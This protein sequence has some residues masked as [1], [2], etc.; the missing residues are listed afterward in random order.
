MITSKKCS[1]LKNKQR[2]KR[3]SIDISVQNIISN[4]ILYK[5]FVLLLTMLKFKMDLT[6]VKFCP[7]MGDVNGLEMLSNIVVAPDVS[8]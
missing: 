1:N 4:N 3:Y 8:E 2:N 5:E 6:L 7:K